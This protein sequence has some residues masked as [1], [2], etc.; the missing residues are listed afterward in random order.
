MSYDSWNRMVSSSHWTGD[1]GSYTYEPLGRRRVNVMNGA[2][3][4][5]VP[6]GDREV[7][8]YSSSGLIDY[9]IYGPGLDEPVSAVALEAFL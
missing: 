4:Y 6:D 1:T 2:T 7:A 3:T 5:I 8:E 9:F